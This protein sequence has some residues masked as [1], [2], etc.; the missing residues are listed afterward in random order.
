MNTRTG[1]IYP[2]INTA[3][4]AGIPHES[5]AEVVTN[6]A[7]WPEVRFTSGPFKNRLYKRNTTTGQLIRVQEPK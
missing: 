2:D 5:L 3:F 6:D 1:E 4:A 7:E